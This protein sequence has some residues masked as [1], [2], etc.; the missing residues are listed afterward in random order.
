MSPR[1][2]MG[3]AVY[4]AARAIRQHRPDE[5]RSNSLGGF[6]RIPGFHIQFHRNRGR[7]VVTSMAGLFDGHLRAG[8]IAIT[9]FQRPHDWVDKFLAYVDEVTP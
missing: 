1:R 7:I 3:I 5:V 9:R 4:Q 8:R 6:H 2:E